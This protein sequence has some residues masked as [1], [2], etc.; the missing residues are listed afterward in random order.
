MRQK[1]MTETYCNK[2]T[3]TGDTEG[4]QREREK[5]VSLALSVSH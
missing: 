5:K 3:E 1:V 2:S 4:E